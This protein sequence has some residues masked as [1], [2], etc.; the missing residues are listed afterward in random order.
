MGSAGSEMK[1]ESNLGTG[2]WFEIHQV[3]ATFV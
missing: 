2:Q 1:M 3:E